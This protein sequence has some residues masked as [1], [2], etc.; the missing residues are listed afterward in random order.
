ME[1][2]IL[3]KIK[4]GVTIRVHE[5]FKEGEKTRTSLFEGTI[6][7]RKHGS[8][9]GATFTV[10]RVS[11]GVGMEKIFPIHSPNIYK[12]EILRSPKVRRAKLYYLRRESE[13][14]VRRKLKKEMVKTV[15]AKKTELTEEPV[16]VQINEN[17]VK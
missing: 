11:Q 15:A 10:R 4:P 3:E 9:I 5:K 12:I 1:K 8:E 6:L 16:E 17:S 14:E 7:A 2:E 13:K